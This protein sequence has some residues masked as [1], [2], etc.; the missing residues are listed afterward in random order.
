[1]KLDVELVDYVTQLREGI[2]EAY[3]GIVDGF[4]QTEKGEL[5]A[6]F[7]VESYH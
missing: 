1:M 3:T 6:A 5:N 4:K 2:L 7:V